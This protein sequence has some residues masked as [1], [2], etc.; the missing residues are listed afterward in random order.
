MRH[1][2][3]EAR[4]RIGMTQAEVAKTINIT[5]QYMSYLENGKGHPSLEVAFRFSALYN[6]DIDPQ[7]KVYSAF[8]HLMYLPTREIYKVADVL[9]FTFDPYG[10]FKESE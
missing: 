2:M 1:K 5:K 10:L 9:G 7:D 6:V 3:I 8:E 4:K